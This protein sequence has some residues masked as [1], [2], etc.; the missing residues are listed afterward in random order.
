MKLKFRLLILPIL[1]LVFAGCGKEDDDVTITTTAPY[2]SMD[3]TTEDGK[4]TQLQEHKIGKG[5]PIVI[6]GDG[7]LDRDIKGGKYRRATTS[8]LDALFSVYP[9]NALRDYFDVYEV[10]AVSYNDYS[11]HSSS[12]LRTAFSVRITN[13]SSTNVISATIK[14]GN[15]N[16]V[17]EYAKKAIGEERIDDATIVVLVNDDD[18]AGL[19]SFV[20]GFT[21]SDIPTGCAIAYG[22]LAGIISAYGY[23]ISRTSFAQTLLHE[24]GHAFGKFADEYARDDNSWIT[25]DMKDY[26]REMQSYGYYCNVSLSDDV[27]KTPWADF[28]AD[29]RYE[30]ERLGCYEGAVHYPKGVY[31]ATAN[32]IM[33]GSGKFKVI[34]R[35]LIY[36]R[37][38]NIAYGDSWKYDYEDFV[39]FD[40][41][42]AK[43]MIEANSDI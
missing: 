17:V 1:M 8:A 3:M 37:C 23:D 31:R 41:E 43:A 9:M 39:A 14:N 38:M 18:M 12:W 6:M 5:V 21:Y 42:R 27:K 2:H 40:L 15:D 32:S 10:T 29:S 22:T 7:F 34:H 35:S 11:D 26:I 25:I 28:A 19:C 33:C 4:V 16:K 30:F 24:F 13:S 20:S 36:K